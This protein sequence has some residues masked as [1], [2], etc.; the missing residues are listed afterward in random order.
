MANDKR[1][2]V[3]LAGRPFYINRAALA[4]IK[5]LSNMIGDLFKD[6]NLEEMA[7]APETA[8]EMITDKILSVPHA[9]L[10]IFVDDLP[11]EIFTDEEN[12]VTLP[13]LLDALSE[14]SDYNRLNTVKNFLSPM[15]PGI[16]QALPELAALGKASQKTN[17]SNSAS[18]PSVGS[19]TT[20]S[21]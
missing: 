15:L 14:I 9:V 13:E 5:S 20:Q 2:V 11:K 10:S 17:S 4:K 19:P 12:G 21:T 8:G 7:K 18:K 16:R 1:P 3:T 6:V